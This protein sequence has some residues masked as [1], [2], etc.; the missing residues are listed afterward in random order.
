M[1]VLLSAV[2]R[3]INQTLTAAATMVECFTPPRWCMMMWWMNRWR[4]AFPLMLFGK[5]KL[6]YWWEIIFL[7]KGFI[8]YPQAMMIFE[9]LHI[10]SEAVKQMSEGELL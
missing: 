4:R 7:S 1:F 2:A 10:L 6:P 9:H 5:I 8:A 3:T